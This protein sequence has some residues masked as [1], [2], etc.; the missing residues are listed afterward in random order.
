MLRILS[1]WGGEARFA[2]LIVD[3]RRRWHG[4]LHPSIGGSGG[5]RI[6]IAGAFA[7]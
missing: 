2:H 3:E 5:M 4:T 1:G 6:C 7:S